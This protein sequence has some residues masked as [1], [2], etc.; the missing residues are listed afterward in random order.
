[1]SLR[2]LAVVAEL[3]VGVVLLGWGVITT[4]SPRWWGRRGVRWWVGWTR[5]PVPRGDGV[6]VALVG[7]GIVVSAVAVALTAP[8]AAIPASTRVVQLVGLGVVVLG[9]VLLAATH[10]ADPQHDSDTGT[11]RAPGAAAVPQAVG[12]PAGNVGHPS[13]GTSRAPLGAGP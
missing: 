8:A 7:A 5:E 1:M 6:G 2:L 11:D 10:P 13:T 12:P 3:V 4:A 9:G